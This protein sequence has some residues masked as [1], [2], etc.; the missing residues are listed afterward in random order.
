MTPWYR[1]LLPGSRRQIL[2]AI[3]SSP[4]FYPA[5]LML[6]AQPPAISFVE[7]GRE[8]Y[9]RSSFLDH[10]MQQKPRAKKMLCS[11]RELMEE[12]QGAA[13]GRVG[14]IFHVAYCC[15]TLLV[16]YLELLPGAFV[17]KEPFIATQLAE[18]NRE[19]WP[20]D[21]D[22]RR[23]EVIRLCVQLMGRTYNVSAETA[24]AKLNDQC[25]AVG[26]ALMGANG[27]PQCV[28]IGLELRPFLLAGLKEDVRRK[29]VRRRVELAA[30]DVGGPELKLDPRKLNDGQA[31]AWL[32]LTNGILLQ[33]LLK[34][35]GADRVL[36]VD[37]EE[38]SDK[39]EETV[40][41]VAAWFG[42]RPGD[43]EIA[44]A[45][46]DKTA[47][48]YSKDPARKFTREDRR[49]ELAEIYGRIGNEVEAAMTWA[50]PMASDLGL[51]PLS[52]KMLADQRA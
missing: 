5:E 12:Y 29:W 39:P 4:D 48:H 47:G 42:L 32:W 46:E 37:G 15:S 20:A 40:R 38:I 14:F 22:L 17:L 24:I 18:L 31:C 33:R 13:A 23:E 16:R 10:R 43:A 7:A 9:R 27:M 3:A 2:K 34:D 52:G 6:Q 21:I 28:F 50:A 36:V 1:Q 35:A 51:N 11:V 25:N 19:P 45:I 41:E 8:V 26:P 44:A 49:A 30:L